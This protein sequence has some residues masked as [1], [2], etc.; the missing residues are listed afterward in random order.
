[1]LKS[2]GAFDRKT[3]GREGERGTPPSG[4]KC[5]S[6]GSVVHTS[7]SSLRRGIYSDFRKFMPFYHSAI[8]LEFSHTICTDFSVSGPSTSFSEI[9]PDLLTL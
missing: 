4:V 6:V 1:M 2:V 9:T 8:V 5:A 7:L 3:K